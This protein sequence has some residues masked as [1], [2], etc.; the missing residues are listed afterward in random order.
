[1]AITRFDVGGYKLAAEISG[2]GSPTVVFI[3][4]AGG[5]KDSW[6]AAIA[7]LQSSTTLLTYDRAG[8]G[9]SETPADSATRKLGASADELHRLL[10][11]TNLTGPFILVGHSFGGLIALIYA[12]QRPENIAGLILVDASDVHLSLDMD[13]P[14]LTAADGD[15]ED[16]LTYDVVASVDE[17]DRSRRT[18]VV[19]TVVIASRVDR[20]LEE[21]I[22]LDRWKP[23]ALTE[24]DARWQRHHESLAT[25]LGATHKVARQGG[26]NI[27]A[28]DPTIVAESIDDVIAA[29]RL[30]HQTAPLAPGND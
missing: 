23:F 27:Q 15:R 10:A 20:W 5:G 6:T 17:V 11:A 29:A 12:A 30:V 14:H 2:E 13:E 9:D 22:D 25:D 19:P 16:H 26:H 21:D 1:M 7:A 24:L 28:D 3:S 4:G 8:I 18:L